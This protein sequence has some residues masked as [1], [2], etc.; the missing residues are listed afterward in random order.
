MASADR[1][2][3]AKNHGFGHERAKNPS[4]RALAA[5]AG[6]HR[7][8]DACG[9]LNGPNNPQIRQKTRVFGGFG[10]RVAGLQVGLR[11]LLCG[12]RCGE[13]P[14]GAVYACVVRVHVRCGY[15]LRGSLCLEV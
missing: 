11:A 2:G 14:S 6:S 10:A 15:A 12:L 5:C 4:A 9:G 1:P 7:P 13:A 8:Q 3:T